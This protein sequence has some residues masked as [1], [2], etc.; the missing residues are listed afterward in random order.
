M[1]PALLFCPGDR[2]DRFEKALAAAD[3]VVLDLEDA[4]S[5]DSKTTARGVVVDALRRLPLDRVVVRINGVDSPWHDADVETLREVRGV[6]VMLPKA[7]LPPQVAAL[8]P[9]P[10]I[11]LCETA[12]GILASAQLAQVSNCSG[13]LWGSEDLAVS[14]HGRSSRYRSGALTGVSAHA[15]HTVLVAARSAGRFAID[16]AHVDIKDTAGLAAETL[17]AVTMGFDAKACI[18]PAQ[19]QHVRDAFVPDAEELRWAR[20][21]LAAAAQAPGVFRYEGRMIDAPL[22]EHARTLL[23]AASAE[24]P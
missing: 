19:V 18:H 12:L 23:R 13:L 14:L 10:V 16:A 22:V 9:A 2:P 8:A 5:P 21:V 20:A 1:F 6:T 15:R 4:V 11:A 17:D 7:E 3:G 24:S